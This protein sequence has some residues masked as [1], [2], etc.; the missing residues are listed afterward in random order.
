VKK[1]KKTL[2]LRAHIK[3]KFGKIYHCGKKNP[4]QI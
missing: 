4:I 2:M 1:K 3:C